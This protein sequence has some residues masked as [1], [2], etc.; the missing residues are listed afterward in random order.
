FRVNWKAGQTHN[1]TLTTSMT[2]P[3]GQ[4]RQSGGGS[5]SF[6]STLRMAVKSVSNGVATVDMTTSMRTP[7][8]SA[9]TNNTATVRMNSQGEMVGGSNQAGSLIMG[10]PKGV[11]RVGQTWTTKTDAR[12]AAG[13]PMG[14]ESKNTLRRITTVNGRQVAEIRSVTTLKGSGM[15][16]SG[17]GVTFLELSTG[18]PLRAEISQNLKMT[19]PAQQQGAKP[20]TVTI[21]VKVTMV[22]Q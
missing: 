17:S 7:G 16:G 10:L 3:A 22:K 9:P 14:V 12:A 20:Q 5:Q 15:T 11:I 13:M 19:M 2:A 4:A 18:L 6:N 8:S 1:Y 21:P